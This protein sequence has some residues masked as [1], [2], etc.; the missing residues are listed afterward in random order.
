MNA[1][2][3]GLRAYGTK[4]QTPDAG[5]AGLYKLGGAAALA[6]VLVALTDIVLTFFPLG[7][8]APGTLTAVDW[9]DLF[10]RNWFFG[11][12]NL[13]LLPN[14]LT[15]LLA[16]PLFLALY[17]AHRNADHPYAAL[18]MILS[19]LGMAIYLSNNAA[20]PMLALS[21]RY[22]AAATDAQRDLLA[23]AGEAILAR[24]EDF[25]PG[26]F[27]GFILGELAILTISLVML[28]GG[29]FGKAAACM[30]ICGSLLLSL[31]TIWST[32]LAGSFDAAMVLA[33]LGGLSTMGWYVL[34]SLRL[35]Q[36]GQIIE[37]GAK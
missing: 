15:L 6:S 1:A 34:I 9:F 29:I 7:A 35:F 17:T 3:S 33:M 20:F 18:A 11:L 26:T 30:G 32:F 10:Q 16:V 8:E 28:R 2:I 37:A 23:A 27:M 4:I 36:L 22:S 12:R 19:L 31:F 25:T 24:G 14:I 21:S 5:R 13:G